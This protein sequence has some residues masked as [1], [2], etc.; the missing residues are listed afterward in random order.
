LSMQPALAP[1]IVGSAWSGEDAE[2]NPLLLTQAFAAAATRLGVQVMSHTEV[3][4]ITCL[5]GKVTEVLT[6]KGAIA[7]EVV[8][9]AAGPFAPTVGRMAGI[10]IPI[11]PRRGAILISE[12]VAPMVNGNVL[13]AQYIASKHQSSEHGSGS[14]N[15]YG[16]GLSL[17]QT[18]SG[19][20]LI[21]GSREFKGFDSG[22]RPEM[23][24]AIARHAMRIVP[25]LGRIR[26]IRTMVGFRPSTGDGLPIIAEA[27]EV[28]GFYIAA[29]HEGDGIALSPITGKIV[30]DLLQGGRKYATFLEHLAGSRFPAEFVPST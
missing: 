6:K 10:H 19:N 16:I 3:V 20:L 18:E 30:A 24:T 13:C 27:P 28:R 7:T 29:G 1:H 22:I 8:I 12:R 25:E 9:N 2:V 11:T 14:A 17:G 23:L 26:I 21:G 4:G 5:Q 15:P